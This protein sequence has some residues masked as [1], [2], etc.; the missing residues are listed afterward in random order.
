M[1]YL[2]LFWSFFQVGL[3]SIGGGYASLPLIQQQVVELHGWL[4]MTEF[5]DIITISQ[6]TPGPIA[7]NAATFVGIR[8]AGIGGA[9]I[10]TLGCILPSC[11]ILL[12]V[13]HFYYKYKNLSAVQGIL[14]GLRPAVVALIAS[15]GLSV[16]ILALWNNMPIVWDIRAIDI[17]AAVLFGAGL[18]VLRRFHVNP[19]Y[20]MLGAG[21]CGLIGYSVIV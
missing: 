14:Y 2:Q 16:L 9:V 7:I 21:I 12:T 19:I 6:M 4:Q 11:M 5:S 13:A 3:F 1:T 17:F 10:A 20:V 8:I 15:A 18:F